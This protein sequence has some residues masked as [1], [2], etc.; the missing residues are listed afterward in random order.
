MLPVIERWLTSYGLS[1]TKDESEVTAAEAAELERLAER[2]AVLLAQIELMKQ[3]L[4]DSAKRKA[5]IQHACS[6]RK[7][8]KKAATA[9]AKRCR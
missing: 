9:Q 3:E 5:E 6:F 4:R 1:F 2:R 8:A 7:G